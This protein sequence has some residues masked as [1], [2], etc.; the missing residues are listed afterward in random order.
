MHIHIYIHEYTYI[1]IVDI[2]IYNGIHWSWVLIPLRPTFYS[3]FKESFSGEYDMYHSFHIQ[4][5]M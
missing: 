2:Y 1:D 4:S 5:L 3:Y